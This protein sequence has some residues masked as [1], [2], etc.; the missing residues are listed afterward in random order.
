MMDKGYNILGIDPGTNLLGYGL[1]N[2]Q[3]KQTT[4]VAMGVL[5]MRKIEDPYTKLDKIF[6]R[7]VSLVDEFHPT[8]LSIEAPFM[9]KNPQSMLKLGRAQGVAIAAALHKGLTVNEYTPMKIKMAVTGNGQAAK[10][11]V[12]DMMKRYLKLTD[13]QMLPYL[14]A[15]DA[16]AAAYCHFLQTGNPSIEPKYN[17]WKDFIAQNEKRVRK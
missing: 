12:A 7:V 1:I 2:V 17:S 5:D 9:G 11:Q 15:T 16:L 14:D 8:A 4:M 3:G 13:D 6:S 10:E